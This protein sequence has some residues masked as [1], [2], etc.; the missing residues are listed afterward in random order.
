MAGAK[1]L[2]TMRKALLCLAL[3]IPSLIAEPVAPATPAPKEEKSVAVSPA[4]D[5]ANLCQHW[6]H[7]VEEEKPG[8]KEQVFRPSAF[9]V[10]PPS[11]FRMACKFSANKDFEW[12]ELASNDAHGFKKGTWSIDPTDKAL[13]H[14]VKGGTQESYRITSLTKDRLTWTQ[15]VPAA[16]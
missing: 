15:V 12:L 5:L 3:T 2:I 11:R 13:L 4:I 1:C 10:F 7:S 14:L 6:V 16:K 8:D 9:K